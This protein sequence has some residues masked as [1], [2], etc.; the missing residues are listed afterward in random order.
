MQKQ[1][2]AKI[3]LSNAQM[4]R[5]THLLNNKLKTIDMVQLCQMFYSLKE[6]N[7]TT[8]ST[9]LL[10]T[11]LTVRLKELKISSMNAQ[12]IANSLYGLQKM[13]SDSVEVREV[14]LEM[15][16]HIKAY[17]GTF[18]S[19]GI[20]NALYGLQK[21]SS[22]R[23]EVQNV[24]LSM[25]PHIKACKDIFTEQSIA[26]SL[27]GLQKMSSDSVEVRV[28]LQS[29]IPHI[30]ACKAMFTSQ[31]IGNALYG[32]QKM[33]SDNAEV[34]KVLQALISHIETCKDIYS[35]E[36]FEQCFLAM[37]C[38]FSDTD[39]CSTQIMTVIIQNL[40]I[41]LDNSKDA[42]I[43]FYEDICRLERGI[44]IF[45]FKQFHKISS[46]E[47]KTS[48]QDIKNKIIMY[49]HEYKLKAIK[50]IKSSST[51][52]FIGNYMKIALKDN[53][54]IVIEFN[55]DIDGFELDI[56][57]KVVN[58]NNKM[59]NIEVDGPSHHIRNSKIFMKTRDELLRTKYGMDLIRISLL[60]NGRYLT[61]SELEI[62]ILKILREYNLI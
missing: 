62:T 51:E 42:N 13:S 22:D 39:I 1:S 23:V 11:L 33:S 32:L 2:K 37:S 56:L 20:G 27:Y 48:I 49:K 50:K 8:A 53:E 19:Q 6:N 30:K 45:E 35:P 59:I 10:I 60:Q 4:T 28:V 25:I 18:T 40:S 47:L 38:V 29:M 54:H 21:M 46:D 57:L 41:Y 58:N 3:Q 14:L 24:L 52:N 36:E 55:S 16:P 34:Q 43:L 12:G 61:N 44:N 7:G 9:L 26:N 5:I 17:K 31:G 15:I